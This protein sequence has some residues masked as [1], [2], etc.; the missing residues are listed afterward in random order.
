MTSCRKILRW[1]D[2]I[3]NIGQNTARFSLARAEIR[4]VRVLGFL[5]YCTSIQE[6]FRFRSQKVLTKLPSLHVI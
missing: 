5:L 4:T 1:L 2:I 6:S 3:Y